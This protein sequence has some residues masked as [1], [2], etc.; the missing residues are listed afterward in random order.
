MRYSTGAAYKGYGLVLFAMIDTGNI[1]DT[2]TISGYC[3]YATS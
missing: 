1:E 3:A 2:D